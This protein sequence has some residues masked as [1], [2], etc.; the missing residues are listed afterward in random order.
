MV[1]AKEGSFHRAP[2][3]DMCQSSQLGGA[4]IRQE[5]V[6]A[7]QDGWIGALPQVEAE[8]ASPEKAVATLSGE[9]RWQIGNRPASVKAK[10]LE[11]AD[12]GFV[13]GRDEGKP[14]GLDHGQA[15]GMA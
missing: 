10:C 5:Q 7:S 2:V 1:G 12:H 13:V 15:S 6:E 9:H 8:V 14:A 11:E 4:V 3:T